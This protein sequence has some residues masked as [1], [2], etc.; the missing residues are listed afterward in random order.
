MHVFVHQNS[1]PSFGAIGKKPKDIRMLVES[2]LAHHLHF[3]DEI[4][5]D[6]LRKMSNRSKPLHSD[7]SLGKS[8]YQTMKFG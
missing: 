6:S 5:D 3:S 7:S 8:M 1:F 2:E 4:A